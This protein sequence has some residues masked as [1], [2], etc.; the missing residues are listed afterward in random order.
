MTTVGYICRPA[1]PTTLCGMSRCREQR[2]TTVPIAW[3]GSEHE[4]GVCDRH[5]AKAAAVLGTRPAEPS[6][7]GPAAEGQGDPR[8]EP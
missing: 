3:G 2:T 1:P 7:G 8:V 6:T 4:V 5:A